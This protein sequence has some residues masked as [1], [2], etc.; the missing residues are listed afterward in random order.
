MSGYLIRDNP[1][2]PHNLRSVQDSA[3]LKFHN[4]PFTP[5]TFQP[6]LKQINIPKVDLGI[7]EVDA[8]PVFITGSKGDVENPSLSG[9]I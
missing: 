4:D 9:K 5:F 1:F 3:G 7:T 6:Y 2:N 8:V